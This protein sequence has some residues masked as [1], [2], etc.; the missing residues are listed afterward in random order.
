MDTDDQVTFA[1]SEVEVNAARIV[2]NIGQV[3][4]DYRLAEGPLSE[5]FMADLTVVM[6]EAAPEPWEVFRTDWSVLLISPGWKSTRRL[7]RGDAWLEL[8]E[9]APEGQD[10]T[11]IAAAV[12]IG[13]LGIELK[14]RPGLMMIGEALTKDKGHATALAKV[15]FLRDGTGTRLFLP[16]VIDKAELA[17]GFGANELDSALLPVRRAVEA[18]VGAKATLDT[19]VQEVIEKGKGS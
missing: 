8:A 17:E 19:L 11:W 16:L 2:A 9:I 4:Q 7:G 10:H 5:W 18:V 3:E 13:Q 15:G 1:K 12:G 14:F 6:K